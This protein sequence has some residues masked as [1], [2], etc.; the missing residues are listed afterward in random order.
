M[1]DELEKEI[2]KKKRI[3]NDYL[4]L[5]KKLKF[6]T[7]TIEKQTNLMLEDL[8]KLLKKRN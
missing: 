2:E 6:D 3:I 7:K 5:A 1:D 4:D 8:A